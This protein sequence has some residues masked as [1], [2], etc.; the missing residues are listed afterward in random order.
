MSCAQACHD[1]GVFPQ[2]ALGMAAADPHQLR[3]QRLEDADGALMIAIGESLHAATEA[4]RSFARGEL[5]AGGTRF[6]LRQS[7]LQTFGI[8]CRGHQRVVDV[9]EM[10]ARLREESFAIGGDFAPMR[11]QPRDSG[12]RKPPQQRSRIREHVQRRVWRAGRPDLPLV[13]IQSRV[14]IASFDRGQ[15]DVPAQMSVQEAAPLMRRQPIRQECAAGFRFALFE[16]RVGKPVCRVGV[17]GPQRERPFGQCAAGVGIAGLG[18]RPAEIGEEPPVVAIMAGV[19]LADREFC[20]VVVGPA[21]E[22]VETEGA[23]QQLQD[24]GVARI[25]L[26]M[27]LGAG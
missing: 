20:G 13:D 7:C 16:Q 6:H 14:G 9:G 22:G 8:C 11:L 1:K 12:E 19:P 5:A 3:H 25:F 26:E 23:E 18:M 24:E 27:L 4:D 10:G 2:F 17:G 15:R 21:G